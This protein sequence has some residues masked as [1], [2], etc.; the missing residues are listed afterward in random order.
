MKKKY[1]FTTILALSANLL[2]SQT[3]VSYYTSVS[4]QV[5]QTNINSNLLEFQNIGIKTTGSVKQKE[6]LTW[7]KSKYTSFGYNQNSIEEN[8]FTYQGNTSSNLIVT[9]KGTKYPDTYVIICGHYDTLNGPGT[10][11]NGSGISV[12]L[13]VARLLQNIE[14]EYSV[15]F[16]NFS[17]EEQGLIGSQNYVKNIVN[18]TTPKMNI[19]LVFNID[20]VGGVAGKVND[21]INCERDTNNTPSTNNA[22]SNTVTQ[23]LMKYVEFYS[24]L[25]P[26]L[27]YAYSSDYVPF[28]SN[29]EVITGFYEFIESKVPH[30]ANDTLVNMDPVYVYNVTKA[31]TGAMMHFANASKEKLSVNATELMIKDFKISPNPA[32]DFIQLDFPD[33]NKKE[34]EFL[35]TDLSGKLVLKTSNTDKIN[36]PKLPK[37]YYIGTLKIEGQSSSQKILI[38]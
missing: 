4:N 16:I 8:P 12:I 14:T 27:S 17:G 3:A 31:A 36:I 25:Q 30:T 5:S 28:Q 22:A 35:I 19:K 33:K 20:E 2:F 9:K 37:A 10:N 6:A 26:N 34:Y 18:G 29:G 7:L 15:K 32:K 13:E 38:D 23:E 1:F 24:P 11:D 21:K